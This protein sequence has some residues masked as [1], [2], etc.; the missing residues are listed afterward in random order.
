MNKILCFAFALFLVAITPS[1]AQQTIDNPC[2]PLA[3]PRLWMSHQAV[4]SPLCDSMW[5]VTPYRLKLYEAASG[6]IMKLN[7]DRIDTLIG[8][9]EHK[10]KLYSY[11]NDSL[12]GAYKLISRR[13]DSTLLQTKV[14]VDLMGA[15][16]REA[17]TSL[18][19]SKRMM[20]EAILS[21]KKSRT[22]K[23]LW[24][25]GGILVGL[26]IASLF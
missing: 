15:S 6:L 8:Q 17:G 23:W 9:Y 21:V 2:H 20:D 19:A 25:I 10:L 16:L 5:L 26:G 4:P 1:F 11:W 14:Q 22:E 24:G 18:E 3:K 13:Y 7:T 12:R